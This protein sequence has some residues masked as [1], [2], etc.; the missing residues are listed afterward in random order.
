MLSISNEVK[1]LSKEI[2]SEA[3]KKANFF[4]VDRA[5]LGQYLE[6]ILSVDKK[7]FILCNL[8]NVNNTYTVQ[9]F[10]CLPELWE[11]LSVDELIDIISEFTNISSFFAVIEFTYK[12]I[13]INIIDLIFSHNLIK[14][15][16]KSRLKEFLKNQ[17]N[18]LIKYEG[19]Y[20]VIEKTL[21]EI[22]YDSW[23]YIKQKL[24]LDERIKPAF[25][26]LDELKEYIENKI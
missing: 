24:L 23:M 21:S 14:G 3:F 7:E 10:L 13:E 9:L 2:A 16:L 26:S 19:D 15:E 25:Q 18:T 1:N 8:E 20:F 11:G 5:F 6:Q 17:Y 12:F 22:S 4:P